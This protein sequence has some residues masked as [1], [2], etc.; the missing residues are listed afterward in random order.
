[1]S[2]KRKHRA[3]TWY[4]PENSSRIGARLMAAA[5]VAATSNALFLKVTRR[6]RIG[7]LKLSKGKM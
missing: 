1:M 4:S 3:P 6:A 5:T 7:R 2:I